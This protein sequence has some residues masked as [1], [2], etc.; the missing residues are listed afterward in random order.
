MPLLSIAP[1]Q[2][3]VLFFSATSGGASRHA[4]AS[5]SSRSSQIRH[6]HVLILINTTPTP[7]MLLVSP[8]FTALPLGVLVSTSALLA[9]HLTLLLL[10][11]DGLERAPQRLHGAELVAHRDDG[12]EVAVQLV[13]VC[14]DV[15]EAL[16]FGVVCFLS[17]STA[18]VGTGLDTLLYRR[19]KKEKRGRNRKGGR[20]GEGDIYG[21]RVAGCWLGLA[22]LGFGWDRLG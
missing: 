7:M 19:E 9:L 18:R 21:L 16:F 1:R 12:L 2:H 13:D 6:L 5:F 17:A 14:E 20:G 22:W 8:S 4:A 10:G 15:L 11:H 3:C